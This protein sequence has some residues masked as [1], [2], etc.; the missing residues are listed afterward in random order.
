[1]SDMQI[2]FA[3]Y[4]GTGND[5]V[6]IDGRM[7]TGH[8]NAKQIEAI[9][10]RHLGIGADG[11]IIVRVSP[12]P[13][14]DYVMEYFNA[15]GYEGSMCGNGARCAFRFA[16]RIGLAWNEA[17]F[18]AYDGIHDAR[19]WNGDI[20][21]SMQDVDRLDQRSDDTFVIDT[22][23]PHIIRFVADMG[24]VD[25][26]QEG[27]AIRNRPE[28]APKGINANFAQSLDQGVRIRTYERGVEDITMSCGTGV[29]AVAL[30]YAFKNNLTTG[31]V[32]VVAD[33][34]RLKV[35][36]NRKGEGFSSIRLIGP[37]VHVFDGSI[38]TDKL[39]YV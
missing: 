10:H 30:A 20:S 6:L 22:G 12:D 11:L 36:F 21:I 3:K 9:C 33:G 32:D 8:L 13:Q 17:R 38:D 19:T 27:R 31:P 29:T 39:E 2:P 18:T 23:S 4:H 16:Q 26:F 37:V 24:Q 14:I 28:F 7:L 5:F 34:G 1:M 15:D 35:E 25:V